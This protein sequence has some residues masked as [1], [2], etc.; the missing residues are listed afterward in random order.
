MQCAGP[1]MLATAGSLLP[2]RPY[3]AGCYSRC[4]G[5]AR[6]PVAQGPLLRIGPAM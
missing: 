2:I 6:G 5:S 1:I 4:R 3:Y